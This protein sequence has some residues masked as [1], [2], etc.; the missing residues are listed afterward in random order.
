MQ[1]HVL[2]FHTDDLLREHSFPHTCFSKIGGKHFCSKCFVCA[3]FI[4]KILIEV[5]SRS[6]TFTKSNKF[7][8]GQLCSV[9]TAKIFICAAFINTF[10]IIT[11]HAKNFAAQRNR[12]FTPVLLDMK[13]VAG[14]QLHS[15]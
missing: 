14:G 5:S 8:L 7:D 11:A 2:L 9:C 10:K 15:G 3:A 12:C 13:K 6:S 4:L 1:S